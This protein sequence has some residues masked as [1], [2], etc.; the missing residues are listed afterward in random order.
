MSSGVT[1]DTCVLIE[2]LRAKDKSKT[3]YANLAHDR[4]PLHISTVVLFELRVGL[5]ASNQACLLALLRKITCLPFDTRTAEIAADISQA[6]RKGR[7]QVESSDLFIAA[8]AIAHG[9]PLATLNRKHFECIEE[10]IL[11]DDEESTC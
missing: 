3:L 5:N 4:V 7:I 2:F 9:L 11:F 6:L 1:V 8:T 10:L